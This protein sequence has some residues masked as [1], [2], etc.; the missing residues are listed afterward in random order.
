M[1]Y[2]L[3]LICLRYI[4]ENGDF[5]KADVKD[6]ENKT[7]LTIDEMVEIAKANQN[8]LETIL[9]RMRASMKAIEIIK[10]ILETLLIVAVWIVIIYKCE[11][12]RRK[13]QETENVKDGKG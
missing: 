6:I 5:A 9:Y 8:R 13:I 1:Q 7:E 3:I 2:F 12:S 10:L 4:Y 11:K